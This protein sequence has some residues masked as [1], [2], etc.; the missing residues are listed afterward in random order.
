VRCPSK[1]VQ[2]VDDY[3]D[4]LVGGLREELGY[5]VRQVCSSAGSYY[6]RD[7]ICRP[8]KV[9][10]PDHDWNPAIGDVSSN[11]LGFDFG[12]ATTT[13]AEEDDIHLVQARRDV[14]HERIPPDF[15]DGTAGA[16]DYLQVSSS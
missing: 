10:A 14:I 12:L 7:V 8:P 6:T 15:G 3:E 5:Q 13:S 11:D 16:L 4:L 9:L 2:A 1:F